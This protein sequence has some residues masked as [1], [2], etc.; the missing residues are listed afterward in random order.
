[1]EKNI[2]YANSKQKRAGV[3]LLISNKIDFK[4]KIAT[5]DK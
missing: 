2:N 3:A 5:G 1:M 4:A